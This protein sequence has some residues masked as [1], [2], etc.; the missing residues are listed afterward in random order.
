M[1]LTEKNNRHSGTRTFVGKEKGFLVT[2]TCD[3]ENNWTFIATNKKSNYTINSQRMG[4]VCESKESAI[5]CYMGF[6]E[7]CLDKNYKR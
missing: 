5:D 4:I 2:I 1:R 6:I 7:D 3:E